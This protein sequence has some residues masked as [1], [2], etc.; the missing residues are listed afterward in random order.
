MKP[1]TSHQPRISGF[2]LIELLVVISIVALLIAILL[3]ALGKARKTSRAIVCQSNIKQLGMW[4]FTY[5]ADNKG[6]LPTHG[7]G[8]WAD[9][10]TTLSSTFWYS[11]LIPYGL[12]DS[13]KPDETPFRC[14]EAPLQLSPLT[15]PS[16][17]VTY[18]INQYMGGV[19]MHSTHGQAPTPRMEVIDSRGFLYGDARAYI[20]GG[21]FQYH[22]VLQLSN[23]ATPSSTWPWAWPNTV[24]INSTG[25][26]EENA[27]FIFGDG[28][29]GQVSKS[30]FQ[31]MSNTQMLDFI[32]RFY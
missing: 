20:S 14:P 19:R 31:K 6:I 10:W 30:T 21:K 7:D 1:T 18:G 25:H 32:D 5:A 9:T 8:G 17:G 16:R 12:Y 22:P 23:S 24:V 15:N 28:H 27:S 11:K 26:P 29:G 4:A 2:T 3:P 13:A